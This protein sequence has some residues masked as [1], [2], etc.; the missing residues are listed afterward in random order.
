MGCNKPACSR[1][2]GMPPAAAAAAPCV[3]PVRSTFTRPPCLGSGGG[4]T[5]A[6]EGGRQQGSGGGPAVR[7]PPDCFIPAR[8]S[9]RSGLSLPGMDNCHGQRPVT[10]RKQSQQLTNA[11]ATAERPPGAA[12]SSSAPAAGPTA[13]AAPSP[14]RPLLAPSCSSLAA[15]AAAGCTP[16]AGA[17]PA[18]SGA[19]AAPAAAALPASGAGA[20]P[21]GKTAAGGLGAAGSTGRA[22]GDISTGLLLSGLV[23]ASQG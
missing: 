13:G 19:P 1:T 12:A 7:L 3:G 23:A 22:S 4:P 15:A 10:A 16:A 9:V 5:S 21:S 18:A 17:S 14:M 20:A 8:Q 6:G 2:W 11:E